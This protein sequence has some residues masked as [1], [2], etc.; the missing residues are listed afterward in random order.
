VP[1]CGS[2]LGRTYTNKGLPYKKEALDPYFSQFKEKHEKEFKLL[3]DTA[4]FK[5]VRPLYKNVTHTVMKSDVEPRSPSGALFDRAFNDVKSY[6]CFLQGPFNFESF[7]INFD[8]SPGQPFLKKKFRKKS[9]VRNSE[10]GMRILKDLIKR[11]DYLP[12]C[13]TNDKNERLDSDEFFRVDQNNTSKVRMTYCPDFAFLIKQKMLYDNQNKKI[14]ENCMTS[15][16]KYGVSKEYGGFHRIIK[17]L[18]RFTLI[19]MS[20]ISGMDRD[21]FL[22]FVYEIRNAYLDSKDPFMIDIIAFVTKFTLNPIIILPNGDIVILQCGNISGQNNTTSDNS[23]LH[24]LVLIFL[25]YRLLD[26]IG[27]KCT[28]ANVFAN[29]EYAIYSDDKI[30]GFNHKYFQISALEYQD[31][32]IETYAQFGLKIKPKAVYIEE[33]EIGARISEKFEFLGSRVGFDEKYNRY[34]PLP[35]LGQISSSIVFGPVENKRIPVPVQFQRLIALYLLAFKTPL[36]RSIY[37][38]LSF[39]YEHED[40]LQFRVEFDDALSKAQGENLQ[41]DYAFHVFGVEGCSF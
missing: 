3:L 11:T 1:L 28:I 18:E 39:F 40:N 2:T 32:M 10:E 9:D 22:K 4:S 33:K 24:F 23:I 29:A 27:E 38:Y 17:P 19:D 20:D 14:I 13:T 37:L 6:F 7:G 36:E 5:A 16:I 41:F 35:R 30:G 15:W 8:T 12:L 26:R 34:V 31:I 21:A 25:F